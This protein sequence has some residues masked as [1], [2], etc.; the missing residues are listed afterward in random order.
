MLDRFSVNPGGVFA[1]DLPTQANDVRVDFTGNCATFELTIPENT[2]KKIIK[3][4]DASL[5]DWRSYANVK[6]RS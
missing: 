4:L 6:R 3:E 5:K 2:F 1:G